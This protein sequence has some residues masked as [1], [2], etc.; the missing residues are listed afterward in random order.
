MVIKLLN[1]NQENRL[2]HIFEQK[3]NVLNIVKFSLLHMKL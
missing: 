3:L 2:R 1:K